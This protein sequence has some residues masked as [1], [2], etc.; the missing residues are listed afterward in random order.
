M[1]SEDRSRGARYNSAL[2]FTAM[3]P[4]IIVV[5]VSAD[6]PVFII[7]GGIQLNAVCDLHKEGDLDLNPP[8]L[9]TWLEGQ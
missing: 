9:D 6:A 7:Q 4:R 1:D 5:V 3:H 8:A 2:R